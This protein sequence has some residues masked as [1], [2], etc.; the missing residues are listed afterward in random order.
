MNT[1]FWR[2]YFSASNVILPDDQF[3]RFYQSSMYHFKG[4]Q[5][6]VS[7]GL[8]VNNLRRTWSSH[9][10]WD[11]YYIQRALIEANHRTESL[12]ACRFFQRTQG[13]ARRHAQEEFDCEGLKWDWEI[14]HDGRKAY[15]VLLHMKDRF[16]VMLLHREIYHATSSRM[17]ILRG[18]TNPGRD[19]PLSYTIKL[20]IMM[21]VTTSWCR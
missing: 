18:F 17:T 15:G 2:S 19:R 20:N 4:M 13:A 7:G 8:P 3:Q 1:R 10:F 14:T 6:P 11:S 9:L 21:D 5:N 16:T 12:N